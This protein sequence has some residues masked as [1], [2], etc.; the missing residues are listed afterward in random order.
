M[1]YNKIALIFPGQGSQY[2]GMGK[3]FYDKFKFAKDVY[4]EASS[5]LGYDVAEKC[6]RK[7][8]L[9]T[10]FMHKAD[11]DKTIFTQPAVFVAS[12]A[13]YKVFEEF[14]RRYSV[15]LNLY[16]LA[17][18]SLGEYTALVASGALDFSTCVDLVNKRATFITEFSHHYPDA[19]LMAIVNRG[20]SLKYS[21]IDKLC[22]DAQVYVTLVNTKSQ[23]V[24]GGFKK[25]LDN[26]G[27]QLND[28]EHALYAKIELGGRQYLWYG[29]TDF[30]GDLDEVRI[31][32]VVRSQAWVAA[33]YTNQVAPLTFAKLGDEEQL[34]KGTIVLFR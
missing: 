10:K 27:K 7:P 2:V 6:F 3:E 1:K 25:N 29:A 31:S 15:N 34:P 23:I 21:D 18:H 24:V 32:S 12:Y 13:C 26:M 17:G 14:C 11:L 33:C 19:G 4:D 16:F 5:V 9:G 8:T 22:K 28:F 20:K 30:S